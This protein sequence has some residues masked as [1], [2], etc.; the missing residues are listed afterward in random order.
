MKSTS[1]NSFKEEV[2]ACRLISYSFSCPSSN[3][4]ASVLSDSQRSH[5][6]SFTMKLMDK[7]HSPK[8]KR[9]PSKKGKP[10]EVS[11]IPEKPVS[12]VSCASKCSSWSQPAA[13]VVSCTGSK[14]T[15][16]GHLCPWDLGPLGLLISPASGLDSFVS[17][18]GHL[19]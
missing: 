16:W 2:L 6:S 15:H 4:Q 17:S 12:K 18:S 1:F 13:S 3:S 9:T 8:I 19:K 14:C 7:F 11:K 10:A 5:L